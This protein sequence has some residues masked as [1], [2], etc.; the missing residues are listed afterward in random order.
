MR[1]KL[2][3]FILCSVVFICSTCLSAEL[4]KNRLASSQNISDGITWNT[5]GRLTRHV[6]GYDAALAVDVSATSNVNITQQCS[7]DNSTWF[8]PILTNGT[9]TGSIYSGLTSD[10]YITF[11]PIPAPYTRFQVSA[12]GDSVVTLDYITAED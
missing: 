4:Q 3:F 7:T 9:A 11:T 8:T 5:T 6:V 2:A 10:Q 1:K 12:S